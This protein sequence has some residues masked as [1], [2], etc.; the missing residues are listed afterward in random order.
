MDG[1][2]GDGII[3]DISAPVV[4]SDNLT[5]SGANALK[6]SGNITGAGKTLT[7]NGSQ[8]RLGGDNS[9][10]TGGIV[11]DGAGC[12]LEFTSSLNSMGGG[13]PGNVSV[14]YDAA[15]VLGYDPGSDGGLAAAIAKISTTSAGM[16]GWGFTLDYAT[17]NYAIDLS[18]IRNIR[19]GTA[20][21]RIGVT[22]GSLV[23]DFAHNG[24]KY[25]MMGGLLGNCMLDV[26]KDNYFSGDRGLDVGRGTLTVENSQ[27][28]TGPTLVYGAG[29]FK[30]W[31][32]GTILNSSSISL[33]GG[34]LEF[35]NK[36]AGPSWVYFPPAVNLAD[37]VGDSTPIAFYRGELF[38]FGNSSADASE[39][40]GTLALNQGPSAFWFQSLSGYKATLT[41]SALQRTNN[42]VASLYTYD[43]T[44]PAIAGM[45]VNSLLKLS[46]PPTDYMI[47]GGGASGTKTISIL[48][49]MT[50]N[51]SYDTAGTFCTY[52]GANG[53]R[54]LDTATEY[55]TDINTAA[56]NE[57]VRLFMTGNV[58]LS[59]DTTVNALILNLNNNNRN[60]NED[61]GGPFTLTLASG[62]LIVIGPDRQLY[63]S[64]SVLDLNGHEG[65][66]H[67]RTASQVARINSRITNDGGHG[68]V[69]AGDGSTM[70]LERNGND[71]TG[72]TVVLAG[73]LEAN[74]GAM[75][76]S[77][78]V[79]IGSGATF[80]ETA[81]GNAKLLIGGVSGTGFLTLKNSNSRIAIGGSTD[82]PATGI[83]CLQDDGFISPGDKGVGLPGVLHID[84]G[85]TTNT[86]ITGGTVNIRIAG[87]HSADQLQVGNGDVTISGGTLN[88][89]F[90]DGYTP[91]Q[92]EEWKII[93]VTDAGKTCSGAFSD[94]VSP[95]TL[96]FE[97]LV[98][99][100]DLYLKALAADAVGTVISI[101]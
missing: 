21:S 28:Y 1:A 40:V 59:A 3:H 62:G 36:N 92:D 95:G 31:C 99:D 83:I 93:D 32:N 34:N 20:Y 12:Q 58:A 51:P 24:N 43:G 78:E 49:W 77:T 84:Q 75:P 15:A 87:K 35:S 98:R 72:P 82:A 67:T 68:I 74:Q 76:S 17:L 47:G 19:F 100:N 26:A 86:L 70:R 7:V 13:G 45:G 53:L 73:T 39:T 52:D 38:F 65:L 22:D 96:K 9:G 29:R 56:A 60:F 89:T 88:V 11:A 66:F 41:A 54:G 101:R 14:G 63:M 25:A 16:F 48:P 94:I 91:T 18:G 85:V 61:V 55:A 4:L 8:L 97:T 42:A 27:D 23:F 30:L 57:N 10:L 80:S 69:K 90:L 33:K 6:I 64:V 71:Y 44:D 37:R 46:A 79:R 5:A 81:G 2:G 50:D